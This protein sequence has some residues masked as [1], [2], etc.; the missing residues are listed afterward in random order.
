VGAVLENVAS[1]RRELVFCLYGDHLPS[2]PRRPESKNSLDTR[3]I[4]WPE[5]RIPAHLAQRIEPQELRALLLS[6]LED[7]LPTFRVSSGEG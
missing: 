4:L 7:Q 2:L 1:L 3:W 5:N 6:C